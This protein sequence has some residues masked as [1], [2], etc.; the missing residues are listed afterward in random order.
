MNPC[1]NQYGGPS[2]GS[3]IETKNVVKE[4]YR[5]MDRIK[6]MATLHA[7]GRYILMPWGSCMDPG[8]YQECEFLDPKNHRKVVSTSFLTLYLCEINISSFRF[9]DD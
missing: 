9:G 8:T 1:S 4:I 2:S 7:A 3:E 5:L 6:A